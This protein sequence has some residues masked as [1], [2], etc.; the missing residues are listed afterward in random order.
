MGPIIGTISSKAG[1]S[2]PWSFKYRLTVY[3]NS[4]I[5]KVAS[6]IIELKLHVD[7]VWDL[8]MQDAYSDLMDEP[9]TMI[10][11]NTLDWAIGTRTE[12][13]NRILADGVS[14]PQDPAHLPAANILTPRVRN[15]GCV[16]PPHN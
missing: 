4:E 8:A 15:I 10:P 3:D 16:A 2:M 12:I 13:W 11:R 5:Q 7:P 9:N 1:V 6:K 14:V